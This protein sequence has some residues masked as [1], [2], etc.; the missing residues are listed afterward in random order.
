M[1][2]KN[3]S[4]LKIITYIFLVYGI[5]LLISSLYAQSQPIVGLGNTTEIF[6]I[7]L[8]LLII[9]SILLIIEGI[10]LLKLKFTKITF[11]SGVVLSAISLLLIPIG[12]ILGIIN[13]ILFIQERKM[14]K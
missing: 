5:I 14:F 11:Y 7:L 4:K 12:T 13:I 10:L 3:L 6:I 9:F 2:K 8:N 1:M